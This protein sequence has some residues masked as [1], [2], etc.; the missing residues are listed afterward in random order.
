MRARY[1][2]LA[3][4]LALAATGCSKSSTPSATTTSATP[5]A[6]TT[7]GLTPRATSTSATPTASASAGAAGAAAGAI[8]LTLDHMPKGTAMLSW[9][10]STKVIT[11]T[12]NMTGFTPGSSHAMH[13][14]TGSCQNQQNPPVIPFPDITADASGAVKASVTS[15]AVAGGIPSNAYLN[16]HL[17]P[18]AQL[19]SPGSATFTPIACADIP[20]GAA[21]GPVTLTM[22]ALPQTGQH[23]TATASLTYNSG[24]HTLTVDVKASGLVPGS[25]HA[26]HIH[27]GSC[28]AQG[29]VVHALTDLT[30]DSSGNAHVVTVLQNIDT[31]PPASGWYLN[32]HMGSMNT[33]LS[34][35]QPTLLFQ[36]ILCADVT[37]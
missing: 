21:T 8:N 19:G 17:A 36:P 20:A 26:E 32:L 2:A 23:P 25:A 4:G 11:A 30:A 37:G 7:G 12:L 16:I 28:A 24:A 31:A 18:G 34:G 27:A 9:N 22:G 33:I 15:N 29:A 13:I 3:V 1:L 14:H 5:S 6:T 10:A 35:G